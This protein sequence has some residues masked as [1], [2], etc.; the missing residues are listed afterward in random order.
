M[1]RDALRCMARQRGAEGRDETHTPRGL[2]GRPSLQRSWPLATRIPVV[3]PI[4]LCAT[5]FGRQRKRRLRWVGEKRKGEGEGRGGK[6]QL[7]HSRCE[8]TSLFCF[9]SLCFGLV[10]CKSRIVRLVLSS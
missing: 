3:R 8:I 7:A 4:R 2:A 5:K 10:L 1:R 6:K 9:G